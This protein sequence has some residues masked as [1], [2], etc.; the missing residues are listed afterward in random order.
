MTNNDGNGNAVTSDGVTQDGVYV[1]PHDPRNIND[2]N[3]VYESTTNVMHVS[4]P[5]HNTNNV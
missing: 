4:S 1:K 2:D 5:I 3:D